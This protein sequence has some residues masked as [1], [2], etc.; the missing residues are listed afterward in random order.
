MLRRFK[1]QS[2]PSPPATRMSATRKPPPLI[3][4][5]LGGEKHTHAE[6]RESEREDDAPAARPLEQR[7]F[8]G[9]RITAREKCDD[10]CGGEK[11]RTDI[12]PWRGRQGGDDTREQ[13]K[14]THTRRV[15][16]IC[17][18]SSLC[19]EAHASQ[20]GFSSSLVVLLLFSF[21][22]LRQKSTLLL[23]CPARKVQNY[24]CNA[25]LLFL[26]PFIFLHFVLF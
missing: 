1:N 8:E 11:E 9:K 7:R 15:R 23:L 24:K 10:R 16:A 3:E 14:D 2:G 5:K 20:S 4:G 13:R 22:V 19:C 18:G 12:A 25:W 26:Q 21:P 6:K 17:S